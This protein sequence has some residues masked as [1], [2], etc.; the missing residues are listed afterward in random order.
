MYNNSSPMGLVLENSHDGQTSSCHTGVPKVYLEVPEFSTCPSRL[1]TLGFTNLPRL[2]SVMEKSCPG[3]KPDTLTSL[4]TQHW[5]FI[6]TQRKRKICQIPPSHFLAATKH[7][8]PGS[9]CQRITSTPLS[10]KDQ[11]VFISNGSDFTAPRAEEPSCTSIQTWQP[12]VLWLA[13]LEMMKS[14]HFCFPEGTTTLSWGLEK[15][16]SLTIKDW[17]FNIITHYFK[18]F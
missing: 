1:G 13:G 15:P 3:G 10:G 8:V 6:S 14:V 2:F 18:L 12:H 5:F 11:R 17:V 9:L 7:V 16:E 4:T